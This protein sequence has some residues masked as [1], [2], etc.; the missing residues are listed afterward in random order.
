[1]VQNQ[2]IIWM[3]HQKSNLKKMIKLLHYN[4]LIWIWERNLN[5]S[6]KIEA[7]I[8]GIGELYEWDA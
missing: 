7:I 1:M 3:E 6:S 8:N 2:V 4:N 5:I